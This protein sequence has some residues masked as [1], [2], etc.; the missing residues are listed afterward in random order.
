[1]QGNLKKAVEFVERDEGGFTNHPHDKGGPTKYG[2]TLETLAS[3]KGRSTNIKDVMAITR[4]LARAIYKRKYWDPMRCDELPPGLDYAVFDGAI[5]HGV[6]GATT[7]LQ[8][9]LGVKVDGK[10]GP[11]TLEAA[12]VAKADATIKAFQALRRRRCRAH[13]R[14]ATFGRGWTNR[15]NRVDARAQELY[16]AG[17]KDG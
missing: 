10:L 4:E 3:F 6:Y 16:D 13:P 9:A 15:L 14:W 2:I 7:M 1:M 11:K 12:M 5:L 17:N 8:T